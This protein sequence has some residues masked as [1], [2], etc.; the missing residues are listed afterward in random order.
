[1][2]KGDLASADPKARG[3]ERDKDRLIDPMSGIE[4]APAKEPEPVSSL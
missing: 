1:M 4:F 2:Q 3:P